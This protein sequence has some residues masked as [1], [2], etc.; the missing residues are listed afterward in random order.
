MARRLPPSRS[1]QRNWLQRD[2]DNLVTEV[3]RLKRELRHQ[4]LGPDAP[5]SGDGSGATS[6]SF[7]LGTL[8]NPGDGSNNKGGPTGSTVNVITATGT[9]TARLSFANGYFCGGMLCRLWW[10]G[11]N[12][13]VDS[14][15][16]T[17]GRVL[18]NGNIAYNGFADGEFYLPSQIDPA[19][20]VY[21]WY[22]VANDGDKVGV[23]WNTNKRTMD[24]IA[25]YCEE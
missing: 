25:K 8:V 6:G 24:V 14:S 22:G 23:I 19:V 16:I 7:I 18:L 2:H 13:Y 15:G 3:Q 5:T 17:G 9:V 21:S 4:S 12:Y 10:D 1:K 20:R 11:I